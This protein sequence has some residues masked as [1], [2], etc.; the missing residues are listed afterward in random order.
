MLQNHHSFLYNPK[1]NAPDVSKMNLDAPE[2][3]SIFQTAHEKGM[4]EENYAKLM[5]KHES[6]VYRLKQ[7]PICRSEIEEPQPISQETPQCSV[8]KVK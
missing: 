8:C 3:T 4:A 7:I 6:N 1:I 2:G 5:N